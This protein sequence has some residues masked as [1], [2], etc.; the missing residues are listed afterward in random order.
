MS[1]PQQG[2][3][4]GLGTQ[5][6]RSFDT[7]GR[8]K[9]EGRCS[10]YFGKTTTRDVSCRSPRTARLPDYFLAGPCKSPRRRVGTPGTH[11]STLRRPTQIETMGCLNV[12]VQVV[13][14]TRHDHLPAPSPSPCHACAHARV[15]S[16]YERL[17]QLPP[18]GTASEIRQ[19]PTN[20]RSTKEGQVRPAHRPYLGGLLPS[21]ITRCSLR[22]TSICRTPLLAW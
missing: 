6:R 11:P 10:V 16:T 15:V 12:H 2:P 8:S 9:G 5:L 1:R 18:L 3:G 13:E 17:M 7:F 20:G 19:V 22:R 14:G 4:G 21:P